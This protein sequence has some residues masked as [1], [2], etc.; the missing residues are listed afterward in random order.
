MKNVILLIVGSFF[1]AALLSHTFKPAPLKILTPECYISCFNADVREEF[2]KD[3]TTNAFAALHKA[4]LPFEYKGDG[5]M[6]QFKTPDGS[7]GSGYFIKAKKPTKN[8]LFVIQEWW[9]L[10]D[11]I[12]QESENFYNELGEVNVIA[13]D[14]YDG[15][16]ASTPDSAMAYMRTIKNERLEAIVKGALAYAGK[17]ANIY[18]VGWCFGGMWSL[19]SALLAGPQAKGCVMYYGRPEKDVNKLKTLNTDVLGIFANNDKGIPPTAVEEFKKN[20]EAAGKK[21]ILY[22][23]DAGHGFANPSNPIYNK[24]ASEDAHKHAIEYLKERMK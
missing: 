6:V 15:K 12:K 13:L 1:T 11:Y 8:Y 20:M 5:K 18:T 9:G 17:D 16:V 22:R 3:A 19:Q 10:N 24:T 14:L 23:Y 21:L 4:P 7:E 2:R